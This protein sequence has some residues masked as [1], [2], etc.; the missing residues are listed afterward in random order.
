M[1]LRGFIVV[2]K[3]LMECS[4]CS[5]SSLL[6]VRLRGEMLVF[7]LLLLFWVW[8][9]IFFCNVVKCVLVVWLNRWFL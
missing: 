8:V 3:L 4:E 6:V 1:R 9:L 2:L 5:S 7:V